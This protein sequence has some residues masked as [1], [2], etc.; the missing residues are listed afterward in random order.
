ML[1]GIRPFDRLRRG[2][3]SIRVIEHDAEHDLLE[4]PA[5]I[6]GVS[7]ATQA[8][9]ASPLE[10]QRRGIEERDRDR[11]EPRLTMMV[12]RFFD[13]LGRAAAVLVHGAEPCH[14]FVSVVEIEPVDTGNAQAVAPLVRMAVGARDHQ[15]V[16]DGEVDDALDIE[17]KTSIGQQAVQHVAASRLGPQPAKHQVGSDTGAVQFRQLAAIK[18]RQHDRAAR[19]PRGRGDQLIDQAR[20]FDLLA[21]AE[22]LDDALDMAATLA[23]ILDEVEVLV[24]SDLLDA[25]EHDPTR[26]SG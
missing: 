19:M 12:E 25:D 5:V 24:S 16:Q 2:D 14:G 21:P 8:L 1:P 20:G 26:C 23:H 6:F 10:P 18:A 17:A 3:R 7:A 4:V 9:A 11:T 22:R 15:P 13:R